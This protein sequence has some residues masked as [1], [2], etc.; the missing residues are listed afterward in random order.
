MICVEPRAGDGAG[1]G[2][3]GGGG[4]ILAGSAGGCCWGTG[5]AWPFTV[6]APLWICPGGTLR[7]AGFCGCGACIAA[8]RDGGPPCS[9]RSIGPNG[10][11]ATIGGAFVP[12]CRFSRSARWMVIE[13]TEVESGTIR[14]G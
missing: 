2:F 11:G 7:R 10:W 4:G 1:I 6:T 12:A 13:P 8:V 3:T 5:A 9:I 14:R